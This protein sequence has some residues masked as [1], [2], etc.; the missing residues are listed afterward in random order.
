MVL[1]FKAKVKSKGWVEFE[2]VDFEGEIALTEQIT[3]LEYDP[4]KQK[5][6]NK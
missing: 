4:N 2:L 1:G 3:I 5:N 6:G